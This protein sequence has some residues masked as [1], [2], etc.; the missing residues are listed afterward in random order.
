MENLEWQQFL[1]AAGAALL[2]GLVNALAGGG[3]LISF[4]ALMAIGV[5]A[6]AA[7]VTSTVAL[8]PGYLGATFAQRG[9]LRDQ[10][11]RLLV[12]LPAGAL[13]GLIGGFLLL[14]SGE[15]L[16]RSLV[17]YLILLASA[18]LA[19]GDWIRGWVNRPSGR[20]EASAGSAVLA[21]LPVGLAGIYGGYFGAGLS[22]IVLAVLGVTVNDSLTRLNALKQSISF[23]VNVIAA[24]LFVFSEQV[25]WPL[26]IVMAVSALIGGVLGGKLA[27]RVKPATLRWIVVTTGVVVAILYFL[28]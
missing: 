24:A 27:G 8:F 1:L 26:V 11:H 4:P 6:V 21:A 15:R 23:S 25:V 18:L 9:D 3:T 2:A 13:G 20:G 19:A 17:P 12:Y 16:F 7:N 14:N 28:R 22:V 5:P 10:K